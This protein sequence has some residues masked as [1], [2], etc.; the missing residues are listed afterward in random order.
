MADFCTKCAYEMWGDMLPP[1]IDIKKEAESL[2]PNRYVPIICEGCGMRAIG[3]DEN[4]NVVVAFPK[5]G[6]ENTDAVV[7]IPLEEF[8]RD[9][10][11]KY[12]KHFNPEQNP[13][14]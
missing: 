12:G 13:D 8:E 9:Y 14:A 7:W 5:E 3:K 4:G 6:E 10:A 2:Q 1:D 11:T